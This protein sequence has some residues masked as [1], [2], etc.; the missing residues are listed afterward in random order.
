M[1]PSAGAHPTLPLLAG[2]IAAAACIRWGRHMWPA[3]LAAGVVIDLWMH[4]ALIASVGVGMG[5]AGAAVFTAWILERRGFDSGFGRARTSP[6]CRRRGDRHDDPS[7]GRIAR[8][9][10][11]RR[12]GCGNATVSLDPLVEQFDRGLLLVGP[13]LVAVRAG[14]LPQFARH[15]VEGGLW[16]L[17]VLQGRK[18]ALCLP[19]PGVG[20]PLIIMLALVLVVV[21]TIR[22]GLVVAAF[23][24]LVISAAAGLS[25][26]SAAASS[27]ATTNWPDSQPLVAEYQATGVNLIITALLAERDRAGIERLRKP[28]GYAQ[29]FDAARSRLGPR[30]DDTGVPSGQRSGGA[31][32]R[33]SR[34][35]LDAARTGAGRGRH[36]AR[37]ATCRTR[38]CRRPNLKRGTEPDGRCVLA[39]EVW[40][41]AIDPGRPVGAA[42]VRQ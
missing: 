18:H 32:V 11:R 6:I 4:Q 20:R 7:D 22:F 36:A 29:I 41:R 24:G 1:L 37:P 10:S 35:E 16:V 9:P 26:P 25:S 2:G 33:L 14:I 17:A 42:G 39:V 19:L 27:C 15:W 21:G 38:P 34:E 13:M 5:A 31:P 3:V 30:S 23:G 28:S 40:A 12:S 8:L